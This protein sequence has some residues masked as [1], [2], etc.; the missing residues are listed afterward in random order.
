M[1]KTV[2]VELKYKTV[3]WKRKKKASGERKH[4]PG[5]GSQAGGEI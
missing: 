3:S 5:N 4:L 1:G 2:E